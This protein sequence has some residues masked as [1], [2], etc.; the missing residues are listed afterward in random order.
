MGEANWIHEVFPGLDSAGLQKMGELLESQGLN[1]KAIFCLCQPEGTFFQ[2]TLS[3]DQAQLFK[4][5]D[6]NPGEVLQAKFFLKSQQVPEAA[7][8][9]KKTLCITSQ[10]SLKARLAEFR[11]AKGTPAPVAESSPAHAVSP[12]VL[13]TGRKKPRWTFLWS[14]FSPPGPRAIS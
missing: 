12:V 1:A 13:K 14:H 7:Q 11:L 3:V 4:A 10:E 8:P 6:L 5:L 9:K 2:C